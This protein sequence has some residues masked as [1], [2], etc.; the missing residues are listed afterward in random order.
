MIESS[1]ASSVHLMSQSLTNLGSFSLQAIQY[2]YVLPA[3]YRP[4]TLHKINIFYVMKATSATQRDHSRHDDREK[5]RLM[6][7]VDNSAV[8]KSESS[9]CRQPDTSARLAGDL[10]SVHRDN[11]F[12]MMETILSTIR[13]YGRLCNNLLMYER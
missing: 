9:L 13:D 10:E 7:Q 2:I 1:L 4:M 8:D 3:W 11:I 5:A 6:H 12:H